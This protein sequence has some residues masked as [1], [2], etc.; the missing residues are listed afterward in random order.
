MRRTLLLAFACSALVGC[1]GGDERSEV[2]TGKV[3][4]GSADTGVPTTTEPSVEP[5]ALVPMRPQALR[6]CR[7][8]AELEELCPLLVPEGRFGPG[9]DAY[10]A[11]SS[12]RFPRP[13]A[14]TF[15]LGQGAVDPRR[16]ERNRPPAL[17][18]LVV[19]AAPP[20]PTALP[21]RVE[22]RDGLMEE[23]RRKLLYLGPATWG[24]HEG[25]LLL[26]PPYPLGGLQSNHLIFS[27]DL[28]SK[29][30]SL[31]GWEPFTEVPAVLQ[32]VVESIPPTR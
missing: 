32:A 6:R 3:E 14:W 16:P 28:G 1:W 4:T 11:S 30:V 24:G 2:P 31:H 26:A 20:F 12:S 19:T 15:D 18:H 8:F 7:H 25:V 10:Q 29:A 13:G 5:V 27:W 17:V 9:S 22:L 21:K 23:R